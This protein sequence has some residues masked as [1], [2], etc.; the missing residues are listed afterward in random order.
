MYPSVFGGKVFNADYVLEQMKKR[1]EMELRGPT[2]SIL[3]K[4]AEHEISS[5]NL[6]MVLCVAS[7]EN[8]PNSLVTLELTDGWYSLKAILDNGLSMKVQNDKIVQGTKLMIYGCGF[9]SSEASPPLDSKGLLILNYNRVRLADRNSKLG[10]YVSP[11][12]NHNNNNKKK[13]N[14]NGIA[15]FP[16]KSLVNDGGKVSAVKVLVER[17]YPEMYLVSREKDNEKNNE[18]QQQMKKQQQQQNGQQMSKQQQQQVAVPKQML[19]KHDFSKFQRQ[20]E[21]D[22]SNAL[23]QSLKEFDDGVPQMVAEDFPEQLE[24]YNKS[25]RGGKALNDEEQSDLKWLLEQIDKQRKDELEKAK[26]DWQLRITPFV[27]LRVIDCFG[28]YDPNSNVETEREALYS[29]TLTV[30]NWNQE[31]H[32]HLLKEG[33][34]LVITNLT[35]KPTFSTMNNNNNNNNSTPNGAISSTCDFSAGSDSRFIV[36]KNDVSLKRANSMLTPRLFCNVGDLGGLNFGM[37]FDCLAVV[38]GFVPSVDNPKKITKLFLADATSVPAKDDDNATFLVVECKSEMEAN[39]DLKRPMKPMVY[40]Q[41]LTLTHY[42]STHEC[43]LAMKS[44]QTDF[45]FTPMSP[46]VRNRL[47]QL[48]SWNRSNPELLNKLCATVSEFT[49]N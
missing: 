33:N 32:T 1:Y 41:N 38:V 48:E 23:I 16:L 45:T 35:V 44:N 2:R 13:G 12:K 25:K 5:E 14:G 36:L 10:I 15:L 19:T 24:V 9:K 11:T 46:V 7:W 8:Q 39:L 3:R 29:A 18:Q 34:C 42:D 4:L 26:R 21:I 43:Y 6:Q 47:T 28:N 40:F 20:H 49:N 27:K 17:T 22:Q 30:W 37:E 31:E